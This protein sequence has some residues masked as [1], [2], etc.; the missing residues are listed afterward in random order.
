MG[1]SLV[2]LF[3]FLFSYQITSLPIFDEIKVKFIDAYSFKTQTKH[4]I[5]EV[6]PCIQFEETFIVMFSKSISVYPL[7]SKDKCKTVNSST[8][9]QLINDDTWLYFN[10][11]GKPVTSMIRVGSNTN[12]LGIPLGYKENSIYYLN[13]EFH[14]DIFS[15]GYQLSDVLIT[16]YSISNQN[17]NQR[18]VLEENKDIIPQYYYSYLQ[19]KDKEVPYQFIYNSSFIT[20]LLTR[21]IFIFGIVIILSFISKF[22]PQK[23]DI[24]QSLNSFQ[25]AM[26][27]NG[28]SVLLTLGI[29]FILFSFC[30]EA[31]FDNN[32]F[33]IITLFLLFSPLFSWIYCLCIKTHATPSKTTLY[34]LLL[35]LIILI[36]HLIRDILTPESMQSF[37]VLTHILF[38]IMQLCVFNCINGTL[39]YYFLID[40]SLNINYPNIYSTRSSSIKW[41]LFIFASILFSFSRRLI[42]Q[43]VVIF[44]IHFFFTNYYTVVLMYVLS[45]VTFIQLDYILKIHIKSNNIIKTNH[46]FYFL[47]LIFTLYFSY[48]TLD[49]Y[50]L[51][52]FFSITTV[53]LLL[54]YID[55]SMT[56]FFN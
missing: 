15:D 25:L 6:I 18:Y 49:S 20:T 22:S 33:G 26:L 14:L 1:S 45:I 28:S 47:S 24:T 30:N 44:P 42:I 38:I 41:I 5:E 36:C 29:F 43:L 31:T 3:L 8:L 21:S 39:F 37:S 16:P 40:N 34:S 56:Y 9:I 2:F 35:Q 11:G 51:S 54:S 7:N 52:S 27:I 12:V 10:V 53:T 23:I 17:G 46:S 4:S 19:V 48:S 13:N 50:S 55:Y 32:S